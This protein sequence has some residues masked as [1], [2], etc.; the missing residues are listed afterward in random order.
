MQRNQ[1]GPML[2]V[3][4]FAGLIASCG[5][6]KPKP[7]AGPCTTTLDERGD[8][9]VDT[10]V[11]YT[12]DDHDQM[13]RAEYDDG[14]DGVVDGV[15]LFEYDEAGTLVRD[16]SGLPPDAH[17][18]MEFLYDG[19]GNLVQLAYDDDGDAVSD[20]GLRLTYNDA[21]QEITEAYYEDLSGQPS[22]TKYSTYDSNGRLVREETTGVH[23]GLSAHTWNEDGTD[24][25]VETSAADGMPVQS[26]DHYQYDLEGR[27]LLAEYDSDGDGQW[28]SRVAYTYTVEDGVLVRTDT[29]FGADGVVDSSTT[30]TYDDR[31]N[32]L[33][34][35][36]LTGGGGI[37]EQTD[38]DYSCW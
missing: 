14:D 19:D 17:S 11:T 13:I 4:L 10:R 7:F 23:S 12:Y 28:D 16:A 2:W 9:V 29:D 36:V 34:E 15:R 37:E 3:A 26:R 31:G 20:R 18:G 1:I 5:D 35:R 6:S 8:G 27:V 21:G 25:V 30:W 33:H 24:E 38:Y 22:W 32:L